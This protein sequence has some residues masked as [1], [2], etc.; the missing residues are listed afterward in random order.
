[1]DKNKEA[2]KERLK[3]YPD[4]KWDEVNNVIAEYSSIAEEGDID[5]S[6]AIKKIIKALRKIGT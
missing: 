1:M 4:D 3:N 6:V 5:F 2:M